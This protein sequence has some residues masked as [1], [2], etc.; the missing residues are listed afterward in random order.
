MRTT[1]TSLSFFLL[2][3]NAAALASDDEAYRLGNDLRYIHGEIESR[4]HIYYPG[5]TVDIRIV[6]QGDKEL[7]QSRSV[8]IFLAVLSPDGGVSF[9]RIMDYQSFESR[10]LFYAEDISGSLVQPGSYQVALI[11]VR[12]GGNPANIGDWYNGLGGML[13]GEA[14]YFANGPLSWDLDQDG[15]WDTDYDRDGFYG[16]DDDL[17]ERYYLDNGL[18]WGSRDPRDWDDD[19]WD[20]DR[21]PDDDGYTYES[22]F[23]IEGRITRIVDSQSFYI[24]TLLVSY[25]SSTRWEDGGPSQL[26]VGRRVEVEGVRTG[27]NTL[28]AQ[29]IE[30]EDD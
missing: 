7:L 9:D 22:Y 21:H 24:G 5:D 20:D 11:A 26:S 30:F 19:D 2:A 28:R 16:D 29:E 3:A 6:I 12:G 18:Y 1:L 25:D 15:F 14:L 10:R 27:E 8:E 4:Q 13:E 17:Y 23:E